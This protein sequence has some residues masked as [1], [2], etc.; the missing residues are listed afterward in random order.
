MRILRIITVYFNIQIRDYPLNLPNPRSIFFI[1]KIF[2][3]SLYRNCVKIL[4]IQIGEKF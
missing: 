3:F 1:Y 2:C 4:V